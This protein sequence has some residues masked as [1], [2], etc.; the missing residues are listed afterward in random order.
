MTQFQILNGIYTDGEPSFRTAY[1][2]NMIPVPKEQ[3]ISKGYLRPANGVRSFATGEG[4]DRGGIS[5]ND[6]LYRVSGT[7][8][9]KI[10]SDGSVTVIGDVG[11]GG[12]CDFDYSF[13][14]LG[15]SSGGRLYLYDGTVLTQNTDPD[16][17]IVLS[18]IWI[19]GYFMTTDGEFLV[20]TELNDPFSVLPFRYGSSEI[21]PDPIVTVLELRNEVY[22]IN[23]HSIEVFNNLAG[24]V[25]FPFFRITGA[26]IQKGAVGTHAAVV[27]NNQIA[28]VGGGRNES[29]AVYLGLSGIANKIST[30]E[31]DKILKSYDDLSDIVIEAQKDE[32]HDWLLIHLPDQTIVFDA[33]TSQALGTFV[34]FYLSGG[35]LTPTQYPARGLVWV[36]NKW[37]AGDPISSRIGELVTD[38]GSHYGDEIK[39][40]FGTTLIYNG[41][42]GA[43]VWDLELV[44]L[45]GSVALGSNPAIT[46]QYSN[47]GITWSKARSV[48]VGK[49]GERNK[50][51]AWR[52]NGRF[53]S[54]RTHRFF[55]SSDAHISIARL[56]GTL[57]ALAF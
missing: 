29:P 33:A 27:F 2:R 46:S 40:E 10:A 23:K 9:I 56:E 45:T 54:W 52:K 34:W 35:I 15:V 48:D 25:E 13:D 20:V 17:G 44:C 3:G 32:S 57:E 8:L 4:D 26:Q 24:G 53:K 28:F 49:I 14:Y 37:I 41:G 12:Y 11:S 47:D 16:L 50:R 18:F 42:K 1:P 7:K 39:W 30:Q 38:V 22:A 36:Y 55:G 19:D 43:I 31:I 6:E 51:I 5:W 21:D